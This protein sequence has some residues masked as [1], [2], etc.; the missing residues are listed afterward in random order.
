MHT[1]K[2]T[3]MHMQICTL[4]ESI[5]HNAHTDANT[6]HAS[7][8]TFCGHHFPGLHRYPDT[9]TTPVSLTKYPA[10][11]GRHA[12]VL[13]PAVAGWYVNAGHGTTV[14]KPGQ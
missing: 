11:V 14:D 9:S 10:G 7:A 12:S 3:N 4:T 2:P 13:L 8:H 6:L 1:T 5:T